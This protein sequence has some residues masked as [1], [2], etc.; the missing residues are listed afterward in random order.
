MRW[1]SVNDEKTCDDCRERDGAIVG[2]KKEPPL[3][4]L[5][6]RWWLEPVAPASVRD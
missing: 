4:H 1:R 2:P 6:C 3:L 5:S